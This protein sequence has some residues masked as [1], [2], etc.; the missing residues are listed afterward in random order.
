[1]RRLL[2][3]VASLFLMAC[4]SPV[5]NSGYIKV[6]G[7]GS[8]LDEA[9]KNGFV[10]AIEIQIGVL[11]LSERESNKYSLLRNDIL[12]YSSGY[13][14]DFKIVSHYY[15]NNQHVVAL[16][17]K[18]ASSKL[19]QRLLG[20]GTS[21]GDV[22]GARHATQ[23]DSYL[24]TKASGDR[25]LST[26]LDDYPARA[27]HIKQ[28]PHQFKV[29]AQRNGVLVVPYEMGWNYNYITSFNE[30][31]SVLE[32]DKRWYGKS[33]GK[34]IVASM[35]PKSA[36]SWVLIG[37]VNEFKFNDLSL[38]D[39]IGET[40]DSKHVMIYVKV[41]DSY[42][43]IIYHEC[44]KTNDYNN[45]TQFYKRDRLFVQINGTTKDT[46]VVEVTINPNSPL[47]N[48]LQYSHRVELSAITYNNCLSKNLR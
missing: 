17:V 34:V 37:K 29:D 47:H 46:G 35:D 33:Y 10:K 5:V 30:A 6:T 11:I 45:G 18:V 27:Y 4:A 32:E 31:M 42:G 20:G 19:S 43:N 7:E 28:W 36:L 12:A 3:L 16:E 39:N 44:R 23:Y 9:K 48:A 25:L 38:I 26:I 41:S 14:D 1:M 21:V 13:V 22:D 40:L 24:N 8:T 15:A 2:V